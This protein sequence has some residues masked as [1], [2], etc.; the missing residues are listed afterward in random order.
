MTMPKALSSMTISESSGTSL[1]SM[2]FR[3]S[4]PC[5]ACRPSGWPIALS[6]SSWQSMTYRSP[7]A[8]HLFHLFVGARPG[9]V[10]PQVY[11]ARRQGR[12]RDQRP[13]EDAADLGRADRQLQAVAELRAQ[14]SGEPV[15]GFG[16]G[17]D[18][19]HGLEG[20]DDESHGLVTSRRRRPPRSCWLGT[21]W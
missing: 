1:G 10:R 20:D 8:G 11:E 7:T 17:C 12:V 5:T 2:P 21:T 14:L 9:R 4:Q 6:H 3:C 16:L 19:L 15:E 18:L 13:A